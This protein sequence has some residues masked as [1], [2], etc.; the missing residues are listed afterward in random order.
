MTLWRIAWCLVPLGLAVAAQDRFLQSVLTVAAAQ[1]LYVASWD[2]IGGVGGQPS[3]GH[4]LVF[5][6]GAYTTVVVV[7]QNL[8]PPPVAIALGALGGGLGGVLQGGFSARLHRV[9]VAL[10]TLALAECAREITAMFRFP[11]SGGLIVGGNSG[12]PMLVYPPD[13]GSAA[14]LAGAA[15]AA[16]LLGL[17]WIKHSRLGLAIRTVRADDRLAA[18]NGI[19]VPRVRVIAFVLAG[20]VAGLAGGLVAAAAGRASPSMLSFEPSLFAVAA[21]AVAGSGTILGPA[22]FAYAITAALQWL[23]VP[24]TMRLTLYALLLIGAGLGPAVMTRLSTAGRTRPPLT[25]RGAA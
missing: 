24:G 18:A 8:A 23:D 9:S 5:G 21:A 22:S 19:N 10:V 2:L 6:A 14:R 13:E 17:L 4:A 7:G 20:C 3:L 16:G 11:W 15:L 25:S 12:I 1:A